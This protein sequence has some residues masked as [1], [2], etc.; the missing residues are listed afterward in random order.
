M[1]SVVKENLV[2]RRQ[3]LKLGLEQYLDREG[4]KQRCRAIV[5]HGCFPKRKEMAWLA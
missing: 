4:D 3:A 2:R 1:H 5:S